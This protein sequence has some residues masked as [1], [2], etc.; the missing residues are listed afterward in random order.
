MKASFDTGASK[1]IL[2]KRIAQENGIKYEMN[3]NIDI[4]T[5]NSSKPLKMYRTIGK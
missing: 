4:H 1:T 2:C 3:V 5:L